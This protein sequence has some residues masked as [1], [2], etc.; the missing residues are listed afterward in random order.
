MGECSLQK[1]NPVRR[2]RKRPL[3]LCQFSRLR[4]D[5]DKR[6]QKNSYVFQ[7]TGNLLAFGRQEPVENRQK[8]VE[9]LS[10][11]DMVQQVMRPPG[12]GY[13]S[14]V[15]YPQVDLY[16]NHDV[17]QERSNYP[18]QYPQVEQLVESNEE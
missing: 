15:V 2:K 9:V 6:R 13:P 3:P 11:S 7:A 16:P 8:N 12:I 10:R 5:P 14:S 4:E 18:C 17:G 1:V